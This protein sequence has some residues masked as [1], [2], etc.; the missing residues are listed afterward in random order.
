GVEGMGF[1]LGGTIAT[2]VIA[3]LMTAP[4]AIYHFNRLALYGI[5]ANMIAV[6]LTGFWIMPMGV[7]ALTLMPVGLD[8][9]FWQAMGWGCD[10]ILW[11]ARGVAAWPGAILVVPA[12]STCGLTA[13][14]LG[15]LWLCILRG[16]GRVLAFAPI[17]LGFLSICMTRSP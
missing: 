10:A 2:S 13:I 14:A 17:V 7:V 6:P 5:A 8:G 15:L 1:W 3:T 4:F 16:P 11:I 9:P 12:I